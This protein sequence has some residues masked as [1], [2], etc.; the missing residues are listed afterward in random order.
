[1]EEFREIMIGKAP[2]SPEVCTEMNLGSGYVR[3]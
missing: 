1:M 2:E 3:I